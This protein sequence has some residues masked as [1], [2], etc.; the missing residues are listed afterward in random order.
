MWIASLST[1]YFPPISSEI[2]LV[3]GHLFLTFSGWISCGLAFMAVG[4]G[5]VAIN[6]ATGYWYAHPKRI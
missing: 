3:L 4:A 6:K 2:K 5:F 1:Y